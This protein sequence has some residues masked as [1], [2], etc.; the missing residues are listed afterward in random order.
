M[1]ISTG[2]VITQIV[3]IDFEEKSLNI[4]VEFILKW[5]DQHIQL[6]PG[7]GGKVRSKKSELHMSF[8][9]N[10]CLYRWESVFN[11][12]T[13]NASFENDPDRSVPKIHYS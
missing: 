8:R 2:L 4:N 9:Y 7:Y 12:R 1:Q 5:T 13:E 10:M 3:D 11:L 6:S